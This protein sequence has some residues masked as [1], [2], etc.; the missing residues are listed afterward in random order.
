MED[1]IREGEE[2]DNDHTYNDTTC[3][4]LEF[5]MIQYNK[6]EYNI[7]S[8][9]MLVIT[10]DVLVYLPVSLFLGHMLGRVVYAMLEWLRCH[11][12]CACIAFSKSYSSYYKWGSHYGHIIFH[13]PNKYISN[14]ICCEPYYIIIYE[15]LQ[16]LPNYVTCYA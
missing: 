4:C 13:N 1:H 2:G 3:Q 5:D 15:S 6:F 9:F 12:C 7:I 8:S 11:Q 10:F 14:I 16:V